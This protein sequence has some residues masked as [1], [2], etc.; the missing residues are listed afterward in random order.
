MN[1]ISVCVSA[2]VGVT[3]DLRPHSITSAPVARDDALLKLKCSE[4]RF[5]QG[6]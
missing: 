5:L 2:S 6:Q 3:F 4:F 1:S